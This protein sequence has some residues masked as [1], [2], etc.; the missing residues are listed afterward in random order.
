MTQD[1]NS[2]SFGDYLAAVKGIL[3]RD[4]GLAVAPSAVTNAVAD[5]KAGIP[6]HRCAASIARN[7]GPKPG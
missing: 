3:C 1:H 6:P 5:H 2:V 4:F 7:R